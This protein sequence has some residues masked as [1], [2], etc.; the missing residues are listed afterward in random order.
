MDVG[1][2]QRADLVRLRAAVAAN[3]WFVR[4][5]G[6][7]DTEMTLTGLKAYLKVGA[8][9]V[10]AATLPDLG[11]GIALKIDDGTLRAAEVTLATLLQT[12]LPDIDLGRFTRPP[13][14]SW[15]GDV[16]GHVQP[17]P[18]LAELPS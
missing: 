15:R 4:G 18:A 7:F 9:G 1:E 6:G 17:G 5:T 10:Y 11:L 8:E 13:V 3:P 16:V 12:F 2:L 14:T